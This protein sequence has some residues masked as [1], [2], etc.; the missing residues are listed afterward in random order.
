M[1]SKH[2][3]YL[4]VKLRRRIE[5]LAKINDNNQV[6]NSAIKQFWK[7]LN[8]QPIIVG[9][10]Q[11]LE[12]R[13]PKIDP[14]VSLIFEKQKPVF[15]NTEEEQAQAARVLLGKC[16]GASL[17]QSLESELGRIYTGGSNKM[18]ERFDAFRQ[19]IDPLIYYLEEHLDD[20]RAILDLLKRYKYRCEWFHRKRLYDL[21]NNNTQVGEKMLKIDMFDYLYDQGLDFTIEPESISG[22][23]DLIAAQNSKDPL[24]ADAKIFNPSKSKN[25]DYLREGFN[26]VYIYT[27]DFNEPFGYLIVFKTCENDLKINVNQ[28]I[29]STPYVNHNNKT[30]FIITIDIFPHVKTAS[31]RGVLTSYLLEGK[32]LIESCSDKN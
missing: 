3:Q 27:C 8:N 15:F 4:R 19:F 31:N 30:I 32:S 13:Y 18:T 16:N 5:R 14:Q 20:Q 11:D 22:K 6:F 25:L 23:P 21:W 24:I 1:Y 17:D 9:I 26:Q 2:L 10:L 28:E 29:Y 12:H 7:F